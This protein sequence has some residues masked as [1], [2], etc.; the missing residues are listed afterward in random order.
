M[1]ENLADVALLAPVPENLLIDGHDVCRT[2][3]QIAFGSRAFEVFRQLDQKRGGLPV[4]ALLYASHAKDPR[5]GLVTWTGRYV[6]HVEAV[7]GGRHPDGFRFRPRIGRDSPGENQGWWAVYWHLE[8][9]KPLNKPLRVSD[10]RA[11]SNRRY[12]KQ[13]FIPEGPLLIEPPTLNA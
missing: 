4:L 9:L 1:R 8:D 5:L 12:Y 10:L 3:G 13:Y 6:Y 11:F 7:R 2:E